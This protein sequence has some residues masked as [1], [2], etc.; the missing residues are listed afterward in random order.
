MFDQKDALAGAAAVAAPTPSPSAAASNKPEMDKEPA[1]KSEFRQTLTDILDKG[2]GAYAEEIRVEKMEE[3]REKIL[4]SMG[5]NE[6]DLEN[7]PPEQRQ[8]IE[9]MVALEIQ[10]RLAAEKAL[11]KDGN[12]AEADGIANQVRS[13][14]NG[15]GTAV[16]LMEAF[17]AQEGQPQSSEDKREDR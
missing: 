16:V 9:K 11:E 3:L 12:L 13:A 15:L 2:F 17:D 4:E 14:P 8:Q 10:K 5:Y 6:E 1:W 7:M